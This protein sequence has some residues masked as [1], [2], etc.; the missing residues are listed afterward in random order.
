[1][2]IQV[3]L[4]GFFV[5]KIPAYDPDDGIEIDLPGSP[6]VQDLLA[7]LK[8][9]ESDGGV[10]ITDG[11]ILGTDNKLPEGKRISVFPVA[12]GG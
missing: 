9:S 3:K 4:Y 2:K 11:R 5:K 8:I 10:T 6:T 1:M 12:E 7:Y